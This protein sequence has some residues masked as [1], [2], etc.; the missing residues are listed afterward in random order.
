MNNNFTANHATKEITNTK[1]GTNPNM[2]Q[3][4]LTDSEYSALEK[5]AK[6]LNVDVDE[7][8]KYSAGTRY[9]YKKAKLN[10][11]YL[12]PQAMDAVANVLPECLK[13]E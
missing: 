7:L 13:A 6:K 8:I 3:P 11:Q 10:E 5:I 1:N 4:F 12:R 2:F 9:A